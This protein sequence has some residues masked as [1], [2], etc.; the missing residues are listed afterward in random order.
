MRRSTSKKNKMSFCMPEFGCANAA[1]ADCQS[2][3]LSMIH[4]LTNQMLGAM[5]RF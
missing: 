4:T 3:A 5:L 1:N 2:L